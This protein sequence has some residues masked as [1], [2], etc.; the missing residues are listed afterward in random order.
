M[1][2]NEKEILK[3]INKNLK[4]MY[5]KEFKDVEITSTNR[6]ELEITDDDNSITYFSEELWE[7]LKKPD[8]DYDKYIDELFKKSPPI[9]IEDNW[10]GNVQKYSNN[11][12]TKKYKK[13]RHSKI[14]KANCHMPLS[15]SREMKKRMG[16]KT[17]RKFRKRVSLTD[18][19]RYEYYIPWI[20]QKIRK[21]IS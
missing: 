1:T 15:T 16:R 10:G 7:E 14:Y 12:N 9:I 6:M 17:W 21:R 8:F 2:N 20:K 3:N 11:H 4:N 19:K 18:Y 13:V 5:P